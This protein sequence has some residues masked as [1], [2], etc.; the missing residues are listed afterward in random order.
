MQIFV[1]KNMTNSMAANFAVF[2][3]LEFEYLEN[4]ENFQTVSIG[5]VTFVMILK[6]FH[7]RSTCVK[8]LFSIYILSLLSN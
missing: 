5:K 8:D 4:K 1:P 3:K 2:T 7:M 6:L